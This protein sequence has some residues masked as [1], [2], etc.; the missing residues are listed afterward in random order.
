VP[1]Y[2]GQTQTVRRI[3]KR[4]LDGTE[5]WTKSST[6]LGSFYSPQLLINCAKQ[7]LICTH[8]VYT[9]TINATD[10]TF[11][12][13]AE[14]GS[15]PNKT[16]DLYLGD[17][18]WTLAGFKSYLAQ[19]YANGTPVTVWYVLETPT[20]GIVN[21]PLMKIGDYADELSSEDA[22]VTIPT[23]KGSNTLSVDTTVQ[24]SEVSITGNIKPTT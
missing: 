10:Y 13:C 12:K 8:A 5:N 21:E 16:L 19:Q 6:Y 3:K 9:P 15:A 4:V 17:A 23:A 22:G 14:E 11:G 2:L 1:V 24:P 7:G 20:T 18:S